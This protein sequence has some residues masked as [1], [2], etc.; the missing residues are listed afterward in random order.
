MQFVR[1][2]GGVGPTLGVKTD[3]AIHS[4]A[5]LPEGEPSY[6]DFTNPHY[7]D[8]LQS[9]VEYEALTRRCVDDVELLA[10][11]PRP[12]KIVVRG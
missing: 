11:V 1:H 9:T 7:L 10:P 2:N 3:A 12:G 8:Q 6:D 5:D 4:L